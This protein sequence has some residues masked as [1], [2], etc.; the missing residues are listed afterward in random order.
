MVNFILKK[1]LMFMMW[2]LTVNILLLRRVA[3]HLVSLKVGY[4]VNL[5]LRKELDSLFQEKGHIY[6]TERPKFTNPTGLIHRTTAKV[7]HQKVSKTF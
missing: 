3:A 4:N 5:T 7:V 6:Q 2:L 1:Y